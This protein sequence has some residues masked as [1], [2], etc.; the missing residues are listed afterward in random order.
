[1]ITPY[2]KHV[3]VIQTRPVDQTR[4][5]RDWTG[6]FVLSLKAMVRPCV[7]RTTYPWIRGPQDVYVERRTLNVERDEERGTGTTSKCSGSRETS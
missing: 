3:Q 1:M 5:R 4:V 6:P 2:I 7:R